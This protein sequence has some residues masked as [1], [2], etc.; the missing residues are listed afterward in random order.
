MG[1]AVAPVILMCVGRAYGQAGQVQL[2][3]DALGL[4]E[5]EN[6]LNKFADELSVTGVTPSQY[7]GTIDVV[8]IPGSPLTASASTEWVNET[9][10]ET[11]ADTSAVSTSDPNVNGMFGSASAQ[12]SYTLTLAGPAVN[13]QTGKAVIVPVDFAVNGKVELDLVDDP[14]PYTNYAPPVS[15]A[16]QSFV[17]SDLPGF[18]DANGQYSVS[19]NGQLTQGQTQSF[20]Q[21]GVAYVSPGVTF[22]VAGG[23]SASFLLGMD[24]TAGAGASPIGLTA[25]ADPSFQIDASFADASQYTLNYSYGT[26]PPLAVPEPS[27]WGLVG[28]GAV[29]LVGTLMRRKRTIG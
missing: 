19:I 15:V 14:N 21:T 5:S 25:F 26:P 16:A 13:P 3:V 28:C 8:I 10:A 9:Y 6:T 7:A 4:S 27:S 12:S 22:T 29:G 23:T 18:G 20:N 1:A 17:Q 11:L 2:S 24:L